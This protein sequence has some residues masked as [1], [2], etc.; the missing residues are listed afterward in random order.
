M[1][2]P[3]KITLTPAADEKV[4]PLMVYLPGK[5]VW[6]DAV[7]KEAI[8]VS[9]WLRTNVAPEVLTLFNAKMLIPAAGAKL[10][11]IFQPELSIFVSQIIAYHLIP[12][13]Q[14][15]PDF[16]PTEPN[17]IMEPVTLWVDT[18]R[19]EGHLRLSALSSVKKYLDVTREAFTS[20]Y[21][22]EISNPLLPEMGTLK[23]PYLIVRQNLALYG[24]KTG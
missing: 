17:R 8:R 16:D 10:K 21:D 4:V 11:P 6:G 5:L 18:F 15:P 14:E 1:T 22:V 19:M 13:H 23:V 20:I 24:K 7:V 3:E 12:P 9:T 2:T